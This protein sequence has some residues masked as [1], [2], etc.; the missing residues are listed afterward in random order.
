MSLVVKP[1]LRD[2]ADS[3]ARGHY[4]SAVVATTDK[5]YAWAA[6]GAAMGRLAFVG[7]AARTVRVVFVF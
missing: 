7:V 4:N 5:D 2:H 1:G 3:Y 6:G